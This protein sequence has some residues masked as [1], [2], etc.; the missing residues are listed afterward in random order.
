MCHIKA[1]E[2]RGLIEHV[3][4]DDGRRNIWRLANKGVCPAC[5]QAAD[6]AAQVVELQRQLDTINRKVSHGCTDANCGVCDQ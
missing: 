4:R 2:R 3:I 1:L 6:L 5:G